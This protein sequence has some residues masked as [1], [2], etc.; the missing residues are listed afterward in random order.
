MKKSLLK[1]VLNYYRMLSVRNYIDLG[2]IRLRRCR[3]W[4]LFV[5]RFLFHDLLRHHHLLYLETIRKSIRSG[6]RLDQPRSYGTREQTVILV[7]HDDGRVVFTE[8]TLWDENVQPVNKKDGEVREEFQIEGW[9]DD[10]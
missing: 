5:T 7:S 6:R 10:K 4:I 1:S 3:R 2:R 8:R 9:N